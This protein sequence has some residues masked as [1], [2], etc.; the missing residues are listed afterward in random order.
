MDAE[1]KGQVQAI[2]VVLLTGIT[3]GV[4]SVVYVWGQ[5][6]LD[7]REGQ[8]QLDS[9]EQ[10]VLNLR[11]EIIRVSEAGEGAAS[12]VD[13]NLEDSGYE[14]Q[15]VQLNESQDYI[16]V[17][18][19]A[20]SSPYPEGKWT[21]LKGENLQNLSIASGDYALKGE[22][23]GSVLL[24]KPQSTIITYRIEFRNLYSQDSAGAPLEKT[25]IQAQGG[26][27]SSGETEVYISNQNTIVDTGEEGLEI[28]SGQTLNRRRT[29]IGVDLR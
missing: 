7:K 10:K 21:M 11:Q 19:E 16:D 26:T 4:A 14:I 28:S 9:V 3:I 18:V 23:Q 13:M 15:M 25:D 2:T 8:A 20:E 5:P 12:N 24:V 27:V 17:I 29:V 6:I 1:R 22:D